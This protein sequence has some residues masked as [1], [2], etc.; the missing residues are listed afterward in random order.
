[1]EKPKEQ[2]RVVDLVWR[3]LLPPSGTR[4]GAGSGVPAGPS[5]LGRMVDPYTLLPHHKGWYP[6]AHC[7]IR[8]QVL[9][10]KVD[11]IQRLCRTG[12]QF[13]FPEDFNLESY[14]GRTWGLP[15]GRLAN[16]RRRSWSCRPRRGGGCGT[17]GCT[18]GR[19]CG[20]WPMV[21]RG[22]PSRWGSS[23][24]CG[25]GCRASGGEAEGPGGVGE[26]GGE[27]GGRSAE[28]FTVNWR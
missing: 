12:E 20:I 26:G 25:G 18:R 7:H 5:P 24:S 11:R 17:R 13:A 27:G 2:C 10:F 22:S 23:P 9:M 3:R 14:M 16:R 1:M 4:D 15:R 6:I 21:G 8:R 28:G 19:W